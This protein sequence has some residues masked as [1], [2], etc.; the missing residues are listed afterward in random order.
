MGF[1]KGCQP[2]KFYDEGER[3]LI[4]YTNQLAW[5]HCVPA[6]ELSELKRSRLDLIGQEEFEKIMPPIGR[7][8]YLLHHMQEVG[9]A[10]SNGHCL[11]PTSWQEIMHWPGI[12]RLLECE[13]E[14]MRKISNTYAAMR[15]NGG[16]A[17]Q[18]WSPER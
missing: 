8:G 9:L 4:T 14:T 16:E 3:R 15:N 10:A 1:E 5:C 17:E 18:P 2:L 13:I 12:R 11:V 6:G 7:L